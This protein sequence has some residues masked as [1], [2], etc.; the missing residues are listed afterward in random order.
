[1]RRRRLLLR[2]ACCVAVVRRVR[3]ATAVRWAL[4]RQRRDGQAPVHTLV[5]MWVHVN[6]IMAGKLLPLRV[7]AERP[8]HGRRAQIR[9]AGSL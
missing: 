7:R 3:L 9:M 8:W 2:P 5:A 1:M 6:R 4:Q